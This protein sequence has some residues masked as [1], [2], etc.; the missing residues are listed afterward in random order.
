MD[1]SIRSMDQM[2]GP[3]WIRIM[4]RM[5]E[6]D[7]WILDQIHGSM[8]W[9][10]TSD[11]WVRCMDPFDQILGSDPRI[12]SPLPNGSLPMTFPLTDDRESESRAHGPWMAAPSSGRLPEAN[13][14]QNLHFT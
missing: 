6:P 7:R 8:D 11:P 12:G 3:S 14:F 13:N 9:V 5:H 1:G 2:Q 10:H 4:Y